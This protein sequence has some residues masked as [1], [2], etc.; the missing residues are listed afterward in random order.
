MIKCNGDFWTKAL[1]HR[2]FGRY[3]DTLITPIMRC[4]STVTYSNNVNGTKGRMLKPSR[5]LRQGDPFS[6]FL[7]LVCRE[8]L[9][10]LLRLSMKEER[11]RGAKASRVVHKSLICS[12]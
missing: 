10:T 3:D 5:G 4:I 7:F 9:S 1:Y 8:E 6:P 12:L 11:L 2:I